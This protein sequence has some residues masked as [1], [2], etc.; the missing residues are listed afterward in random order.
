MS[1]KIKKI[2]AENRGFILLML[3]MLF[4]RSAVADWYGVPSSS[5]YPTLMI[6][7][8]ILSN[9]LAYDLKL[10]FTDIIVTH[11][12]EPQRGDVVTLSS[13][14]DGVRLVKR[15]VAVPG[16]IVEMRDEKLI[17]NGVEANYDTTVGHY[18]NQLPPDSSGE[19]VVLN[20]KLLGA[21]HPILIMPDRPALRS[22]APIKVPEGQYML[23]GDNRDN[24]KDSRYIGFARRELLTGRVSRVIFSLDADNHYL[25]RSGRWIAP[26]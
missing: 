16:D 24:S 19:K 10:P 15:L 9:R 20:E 14:E 11:L 7:D 4:V 1:V 26:L 3:G 21:S 17:I 13:P 18:A 5:M 22:F 25:P 6:G 2:L 8:R 23:L 12:G